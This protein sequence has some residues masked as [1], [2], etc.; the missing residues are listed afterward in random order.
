L[1][2]AVG[3]AV[4]SYIVALECW[5]TRGTEEMREREREEEEG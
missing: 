3:I 4:T 2:L 5:N 1:S